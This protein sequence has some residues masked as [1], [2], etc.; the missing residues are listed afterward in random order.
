[1]ADRMWTYPE[2]RFITANKLRMGAVELAQHLNREFH[3]GIDVRR[4]QDVEKI[5]RGRTIL[6]KNKSSWEI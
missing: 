2:L 4:P 5:K 3:D 1:M 6:N